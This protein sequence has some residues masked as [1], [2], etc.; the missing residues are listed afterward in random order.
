[1]KI[2][3]PEQISLP[4][5]PNGMYSANASG[6]RVKTSNEGNPYILWEFTLLSQGPSSEV[7]TIGRKVFDQTTLTEKSL[8]RL[9]S[10]LQATGNP[11]LNPG[12]EFEIDE[13]I[14]YAT[15]RILN[16]NLVILI[17]HEVYLGQKRTR[18]TEFRKISTY[19]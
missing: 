12:E 4:D 18:V 11:G 5:V 1:M 19:T 15:A 10:L 6:Y 3:V 9:D 2:I 17:D 7:S 8:W 13:L 14:A 16:K